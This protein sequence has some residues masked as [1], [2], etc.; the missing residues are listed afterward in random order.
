MFS[1]MIVTCSMRKIKRLTDCYKVPGFIPRHKVA[2]V[3]GDPKARVIKFYRI[4][5]KR[6][7]RTAARSIV[8]FMT[9]RSVVSVIFHVATHGSTLSWRSAALT[10]GNAGK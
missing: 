2:G 1:K 4:E 7:V 5:K 9:A 8:D 10:A 3:F 6:V